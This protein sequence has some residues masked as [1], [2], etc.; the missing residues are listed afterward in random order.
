MVVNGQKDT[1]YRDYIPAWVQSSVWYQIFPER[2]YPGKRELYKTRFLYPVSKNIP[3][4]NLS[5]WTKDWYSR[6]TWEESFF[7]GS[8]Y[9]SVHSRYYGGDLPGIEKKIPYLKKLGINALYMTPVFYGVSSHKYDAVCHH[10]IDPFFGPDPERDLTQLRMARESDDPATW[11]W[12]EADRYF[13]HLVEILHENDIRIIIDGVF[14]HT[15]R[16][17]FAFRDI[18]EKGKDSSYADWYKINRWDTNLPDGFEYKG[19]CGTGF[20]PEFRQV[21]GTLASGPAEY[22]SNIVKRWTR[23]SINPNAGVDGWRLDVASCVPLPFW[24]Q[25]RK[26]VRKC[27]PEAYITAEIVDTAPHCFQSPSFDALMNYPFGHIS[28][29]FFLERKFT[30]EETLLRLKELINLYPRSVAHAM[31]NVYNSHDTPRLA[32]QIVNRHIPASSWD[33]LFFPARLKDNPDYSIQAPNKEDTALQ[34]L[35]LLL[36]FAFVGAPLI[37]YG[38]ETGMWGANDP[39]CRKPMVWQEWNYSVEKEHPFGKD[40]F[41]DPVLFNDDLFQFYQKLISVRKKYSALQNGEFIPLVN[42]SKQALQFLRKNHEQTI[43]VV[44]NQGKDTLCLSFDRTYTPL[45]GCFQSIE[46]RE[47]GIHLPAGTGEF[48]LLK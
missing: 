44:I 46:Y 7:K 33:G 39:D 2:F 6:D 28:R 36:Q 27:N 11:I 40:R 32:S 24:E 37:Y 30:P 48:F 19:W 18:L 25:F 9:R 38:E 45:L 14:N 8:F 4:W 31:Q 43:R 47:A 23:P 17:F 5:S 29:A 22:V 41:P 26:W 13:L 34:K 21:N 20:L 3:G 42:D 1:F 35:M 10:H 12:T 16:H 15:G